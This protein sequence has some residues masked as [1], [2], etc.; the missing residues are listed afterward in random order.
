VAF[1]QVVV[2]NAGP[3]DAQNVVVTDTLPVS[4]TFAGG[5][6]ACS[7]VARTVTCAL[8]TLA[9]GATRTLLVQAQVDGLAAD[10]LTLTNMVTATSPTAGGPVTAV[11]TSTVRQP[12]GGPVDLSIVKSG[13]VTATAGQFIVYRLVVA[14]RGPATATAASLVDALPD[15]VHFVAASNPRGLCDSGVTCLLGDLPAGVSA[16]V[17]ITG[18]VAPGV[19]SGTVIYNQAEIFS[20][21]V[22]VDP[23]NNRAT[24]DGAIVED[25]AWLT[26]EKEATPPTV[27]PG[28]QIIYRIVVRNYGPSVARSVTVS[29][30]LPSEVLFPLIS[31]SESGCTGLPCNL[32]DLP[33]GS[34]FARCQRDQ[35]PRGDPDRRYRRHRRLEGCLRHSGCRR[36]VNLHL[37]RLQCRPVTRH[38]CPG[39]R[40]LAGGH[41]LC[42]SFRCLQRCRSDGHLCD[43]S[44][45][46]Q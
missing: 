23:A 21:N 38:Q 20:S 34:S 36:T 27:P 42:P 4:T 13:P 3:S 12:A 29:D 25:L 40:H 15:G 26:I 35:R 24:S 5:D 33:P 14:N 2:H 39:S 19:V 32:G 11:V 1:Y 41:A 30:L 43:G 9:A 28:G 8:G 7:A 18:L 6:A 44:A 16:T 46:G 10:G 45:G 22:D 17:V 31:S 37:D